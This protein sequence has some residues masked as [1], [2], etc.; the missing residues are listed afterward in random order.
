MHDTDEHYYDERQSND[1]RMEYVR[2]TG[3][4]HIFTPMMWKLSRR[5][6]NKLEALQARHHMKG[7]I[8]I[9]LPS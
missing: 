8:N 7:A 3:R 1:M 9:T 6:F 4:L 5:H 2:K